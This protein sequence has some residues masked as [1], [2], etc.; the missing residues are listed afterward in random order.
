MAG[1]VN[2]W[3]SIQI[4]I[5]C[6]FCLNF[7]RMYLR[8]FSDVVRFHMGVLAEVR[9]NKNNGTGMF[10]PTLDRLN[11]HI[12][13]PSMEVPDSGFAILRYTAILVYSYEILDCGWITRDEDRCRFVSHFHQKGYAETCY[14]VTSMSQ[15]LFTNNQLDEHVAPVVFFIQFPWFSYL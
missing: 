7:T 10:L 8:I 5:Q 12:L 4:I 6:H 3:G 9:F 13:I 1:L 2:C 15:R 14:E 11:R